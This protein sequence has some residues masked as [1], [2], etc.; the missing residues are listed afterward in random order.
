MRELSAKLACLFQQIKTDQQLPDTGHH[1]PAWGT[2]NLAAPYII[3]CWTKF[4]RFGKLLLIIY[5]QLYKRG[6]M[7]TLLLCNLKLFSKAAF[8]LL[9][10]I[11]TY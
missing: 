3:G 7:A 11:P 9:L 5:G 4:G 1:L 6:D 2:K 10:E 8:T